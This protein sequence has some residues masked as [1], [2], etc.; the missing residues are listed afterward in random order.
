MIPFLQ[1]IYKQFTNVHAESYHNQNTADKVTYP[2]LTYD[3]D[4][5]AL[6]TNVEGFYIDVDIFDNSGSFL[7]LF[8]LEGNLKDYFKDNVILNEENLLRFN[9]LRST[10]IPTGDKLLRRRNIQ[11]YC[12]VDW[13]N[14]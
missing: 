3:F 9:F 8:E 14:K 1:E 2:Y 12:K 6:E 4:S 10:K 11:I 13:R 7:N 5:E